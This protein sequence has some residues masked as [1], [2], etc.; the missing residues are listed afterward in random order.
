[1]KI[2]LVTIIYCKLFFNILIDFSHLI[3]IRM[4]NLQ[5]QRLI[6]F[7][8]SDYYTYQCKLFFSN[9]LIIKIQF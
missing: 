4:I 2:G 6:W 9:K 1:M 7:K 3:T 5:I 8:Q